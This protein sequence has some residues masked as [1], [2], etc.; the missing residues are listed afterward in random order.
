[1][2]HH[3]IGEGETIPNSIIEHIFLLILSKR[4]KIDVTLFV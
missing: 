4:I 3:Q 2:T 1:M